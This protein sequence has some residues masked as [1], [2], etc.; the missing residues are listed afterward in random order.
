MKHNQKT[1]DTKK[2]RWILIQSRFVCGILLTVSFFFCLNSLFNFKFA[3]KTTIRSPFVLNKVCQS[4]NV[5]NYFQHT[6]I[7]IAHKSCRI[8][9]TSTQTA[10]RLRSG[11]VRFY[12]FDCV[13]RG[14][15]FCI[16]YTDLDTFVSLS[17][18]IELQINRWI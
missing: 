12:L 5:S 13:V 2:K 1:T 9:M 4:K 6:I 11:F 10:T 3:K 14:T 16:S 7:S 15:V 8:R 18:L 17:R